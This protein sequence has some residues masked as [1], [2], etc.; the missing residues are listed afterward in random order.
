MFELYFSG[1]PNSDPQERFS[2]SNTQIQKTPAQRRMAG[3]LLGVALGASGALVAFSGSSLLAT[4]APLSQA[5]VAPQQGFAPLVARVKPAVVQIATISTAAADQ[6][7][8]QSDALPHQQMPDMPGPF[9]DMLRRYFGQHGGG[10]QLEQ[11][12]LGSGF[13]IDPAGYIVTNNHVVDGAH[14]VSV[15]LTDGKKYKAKVIGR[16]AKTD[17]A[18]V[19]ID[20]GHPLPYV[21]FGD[22]DN[23][24]EGDWVIA[25]GNPYGLGGTVTAGI[26]SGHGRDINA[27]PYDDFLQI[28]A[29]I[30]PGNSGGPLFNQ[31]GQVVGIDTAI[32]SPSGGSVGI[33]FAIPSNVAKNI[34]DQLR[35]HGRIARGY[36]GVQMQPLTD[37]LAKAVGL[38]NDQG[39]LVDAVTKDSPASRA[40]LEQGDVITA[41]NGHPVTGT[42]DL[43]MAVADTPSGKTVNITLWRDNHSRTVPITVGTQDTTRVASAGDAAQ[44]KPVGMSL[45]ALTPDM[46]DQLN[47]P[48]GTP[49]VVVANVT[50]G[51]NADESGVQA[52]DLIQRIG[53]TPV[54]SPDQVADAIHA[55]QHSKKGA[56]SM[57]VTRNGVSSYLGLQL[58][59]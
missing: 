48:A 47:V 28:D 13:I 19:K 7:N 40:N 3:L 23:E 20:A 41:F 17:V 58:Q 37:T 45:E 25:V 16:D 33:G 49:G 10:A 6:D 59:A 56:I 53:G 52:G 42:R 26:V 39:V 27:G 18:L 2:M 36:L 51:S 50:P 24:H 21:S 55:A 31:S 38:A 32:Y 9:G 4:A 35:E 14:A 57:L 29:P 22:S 8:D 30:N 5:P 11:R 46:R 15:T 1:T 54:R 12:A 44:D 43:A 34:V